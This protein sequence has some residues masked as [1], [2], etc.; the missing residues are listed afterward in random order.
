MPE[1]L[2]RPKED[3]FHLLGNSNET[4]KKELVQPIIASA[5]TR[6]FETV[7]VVHSLEVSFNSSSVCLK[8]SNTQ[9]AR[10][11][12]RY[13][14]VHRWRRPSTAQNFIIGNVASEVSSSD[15]T[16]VEDISGSTCSKCQWP[17][18]YSCIAVSRLCVM[19]EKR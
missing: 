6:T 5:S 15:V 7:K 9:Q 13:E 3:S 18:G 1:T 11:P 16:V 14:E 12:L 19:R 17:M 4:E 8:R 10:C 2:L